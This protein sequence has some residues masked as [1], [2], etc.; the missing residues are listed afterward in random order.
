MQVAHGWHESR[1]PESTQVLAQ[2]GD[3][4]NDMHQ[5]ILEA[6]VIEK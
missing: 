4:V 2:V 3:G 6:K 1:T 5:K